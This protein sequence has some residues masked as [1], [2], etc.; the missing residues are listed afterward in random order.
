MDPH[1]FIEMRYFRMPPLISY[2]TEM[3]F[4]EEFK[5]SLNIISLSIISLS[6]SIAIVWVTSCEEL[7]L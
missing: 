7:I 1:K 2:V 5:K 6:K 3:R 4:L